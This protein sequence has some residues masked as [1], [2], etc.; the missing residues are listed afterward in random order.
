VVDGVLCDGVLCDGVLCDGVLCD[1][2]LCDGVL[3]DGDSKYYVA[4][5]L[6]FICN[7]KKGYLDLNKPLGVASEFRASLATSLSTLIQ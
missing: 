7:A 5:R 1:G 3:F 4:M 6:A 2:V